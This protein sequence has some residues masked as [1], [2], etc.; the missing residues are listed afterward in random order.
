M[1]VF[2]QMAIMSKIEKES[3]M[4]FSYLYCHICL[5]LSYLL[6]FLSFLSFLISFLTS[7][8]LIN[9][10]QSPSHIDIENIQIRVEFD[11]GVLSSYDA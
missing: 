3:F 5:F 4:T 6:S 2:L 8:C 10:A 7:S 1:G 9:G 11:N